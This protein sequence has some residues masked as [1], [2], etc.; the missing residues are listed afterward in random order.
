MALHYMLAKDA[1]TLGRRR[2]RLAAPPI[3]QMASRTRHVCPICGK[4]ARPRADNAAFPFCA[5]P[6]KLVD[7]GS[8]LDDSYRIPGP[9]IGLS[10][11]GSF[12]LA[13]PMA[14]IDHALDDAHDLGDARAKEDDE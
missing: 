7:L 3:L 8:W 6:C 12:G 2:H 10:G 5:P 1:A 9:P 14:A 11:S 4:E 13:D